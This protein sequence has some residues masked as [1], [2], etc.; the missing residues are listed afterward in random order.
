MVNMTGNIYTG[1]LWHI[2]SSAYENGGCPRFRFDPVSDS[3]I[4]NKSSLI[5]QPVAAHILAT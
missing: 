3:Y 4:V 2:K 1:N 5:S